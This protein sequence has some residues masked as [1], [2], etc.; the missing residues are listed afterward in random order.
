M[1]EIAEI[2]PPTRQ[3]HRVWRFVTG[4]AAIIASMSLV[5]SAYY[6]RETAREQHVQSAE[7]E[8]AN[9]LIAQANFIAFIGSKIGTDEVRNALLKWVLPP[10][11]CDEI[12]GALLLP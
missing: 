9:C 1:S 4:F 7:L 2:G 10:D 5:T 12:I 6:E 8:K 11:V 3:D